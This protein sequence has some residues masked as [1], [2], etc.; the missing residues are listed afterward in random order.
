MEVN[1]NI[2]RKDFIAAQE[3]AYKNSPAV[4]RIKLFSFL[5]IVLL[6]LFSF[7]VIDR[8]LLWR[9]AFVLISGLSY[10]CIM[11]VLVSVANAYSFRKAIPQGEDNNG[12]LGAHKIILSPKGLIESTNVNESLHAWHSILR[13]E[14]TDEH[15]FIYVNSVHAH[16]V[17]KRYFASQ[18]AAENFVAAVESYRIATPQS[19]NAAPKQFLDAECRTPTERIFQD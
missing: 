7:I 15:I 4:K 9:F 19:I 14:Q 6:I 13:V 17:P 11:S 16:I 5:P 10:F 8:S 2:E 3:F 12:I 18:Q 1:Y